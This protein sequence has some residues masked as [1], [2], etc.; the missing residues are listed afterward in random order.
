MWNDGWGKKKA[1]LKVKVKV[2]LVGNDIHV[3]EFGFI[4]LMY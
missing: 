4:A 2:I 3:I 1:F